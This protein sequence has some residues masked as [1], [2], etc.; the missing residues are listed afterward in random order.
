[1]GLV[2]EPNFQEGKISRLYNFQEKKPKKPNLKPAAWD[3]RMVTIITGQL[4]RELSTGIQ[5][6]DEIVRKALGRVKLSKQ[7][8]SDAGD[9]T[10]IL[11]ITEAPSNSS[12]RKT[13]PPWSMH[14]HPCINAALI[15]DSIHHSK[16]SPPSSL[17]FL[18]QVALHLEFSSSVPVLC[19]GIDANQARFLLSP[20]AWTCLPQFRRKPRSATSLISHHLAKIPRDTCDT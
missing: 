15:F 2:M 12:R 20:I 16:V 9:M 4:S 14:M 5:K 17:S 1:M 19:R 10:R 18:L 6:A 3:H 13:H 11:S 7:Q 8:D